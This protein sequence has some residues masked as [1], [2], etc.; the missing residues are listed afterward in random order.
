MQAKKF[1]SDG[2]ISHSEAKERYSLA[3]DL[4]QKVSEALLLFH[5][6]MSAYVFIYFEDA[7][8]A[9]SW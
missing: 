6:V 4:P 9:V 8:G 2:R 7:L 1:A 5:V 3:Q